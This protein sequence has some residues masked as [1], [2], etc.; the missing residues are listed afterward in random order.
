[1]T[2]TNRTAIEAIGLVLFAFGVIYGVILL[3]P[4]VWT[5]AICAVLLGAVL[6][7][8]ARLAPEIDEGDE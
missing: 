8:A 2:E 6:I 4:F 1:M 7:A 5:V 3:T